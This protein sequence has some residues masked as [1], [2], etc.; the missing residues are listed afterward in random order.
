ME[1]TI[2]TKRKNFDRH[3]RNSTR[4]AV[5]TGSARFNRKRLLADDAATIQRPKP[6]TV[7]FA[8]QNP[9]VRARRRMDLL[10][11]P[12]LWHASPILKPQFR[13]SRDVGAA[14]NRSGAH[15]NHRRFWTWLRLAYRIGLPRRPQ[16]SCG[17]SASVGRAFCAD[18]REQ[19]LGRNRAF[20]CRIRRNDFRLK[21]QADTKKRGHFSQHPRFSFKPSS[22]LDRASR[23][24][25]SFV[26]RPWL[27]SSRTRWLLRLA[28]RR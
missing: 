16:Q 2:I 15:V 26:R 23:L 3:S 9:G 4:F 25:R 24:L 11:P 20:L 17:D 7:G 22:Y 12:A 8:R 18:L 6:E 1:S 10:L 14:R 13:Q 5:A 27:R 28:R 19:S 21:T